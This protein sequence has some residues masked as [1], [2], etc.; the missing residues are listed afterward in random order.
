MT[1]PF[2]REMVMYI[3]R[4]EKQIVVNLPATCQIA[5]A[6]SKSGGSKHVNLKGLKR[7]DYL[8]YIN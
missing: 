2:L 1:Y 4:K 6:S 3:G 8:L 5:V 7:D